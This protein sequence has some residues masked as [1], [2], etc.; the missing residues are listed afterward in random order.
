MLLPPLT[1]STTMATTATMTT[2][3]TRRKANTD[4]TTTRMVVY[5]A[6]ANAGVGVVNGIVNGAVVVRVVVEVTIGHWLGVEPD[7][8]RK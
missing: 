1:H 6:G 3:P 8:Y 5:G 4:H 2:L 7:E